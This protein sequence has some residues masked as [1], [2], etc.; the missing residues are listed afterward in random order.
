MTT[1]SRYNKKLKA[2]GCDMV[3]PL[4]HLYEFQDEK[5]CEKFDFPVVLSGHDHH[6]VDRV[7]SGSRLLK[8]GMD[9]HYAVVLDLV[10]NNASS[11]ATPQ[12]ESVTIPVADYAADEELEKE[13]KKAYA[14]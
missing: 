7:H 11:D 6:R 9:G 14:G 10:W 4:C 13:M 3:L 8:P 5:T 2:D 12:I 1:S